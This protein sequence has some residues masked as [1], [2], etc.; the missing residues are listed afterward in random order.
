MNP[1]PQG[2]V[3]W[4]LE[5]DEFDQ[6]F[7]YVGYP[8]KL[9]DLAPE[10]D[11]V[12]DQMFAAFKAAGYQVGMTLRPGDFQTGPTSAL[13]ATCLASSSSNVDL[14]DIYIATDGTYPN[15]G[16]T[17]TATNTWSNVNARWPYHQHSPQDDAT[18]LS[19][20][21]SKVTYARNRWGARIYY[22]DSTVYSGN[23]GGGRSI[24]I[25]FR[26]LQQT[27]S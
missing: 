13:P 21:E 24:S 22:V 6:Y 8:N 2:I 20:L 27:F 15:R 10:M 3:L 12:A 17:C 18:L 1:R 19:N 9:H 4:D 26:Q 25:F 16:Y 11:A 5:G 7:T 14:D 23:G